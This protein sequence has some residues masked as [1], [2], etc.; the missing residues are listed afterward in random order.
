VAFEH[1]AMHLETFL[2]MLVQSSDTLPPPGITRP[3]FASLRA[4]EKTGSL[5]EDSWIEVPNMTIDVGIDDP[6]EP[7]NSVPRYLGW[8]NEKPV[9]KGIEV[10][11]FSVRTHPITN[12]EYA[13][14]LHTTSTTGTPASWEIPTALVSNGIPGTGQDETLRNGCPTELSEFIGSLSVKTVFG[15]VPLNL[16]LDWPVMASYGELSSCVKW[17]GGRIPSA[18]EVRAAY[19][20]IE[21]LE[22]VE[23]KLARGIDAVNGFVHKPTPKASQLKE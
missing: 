5:G 12:G 19:Q 3:D 17:M 4:W 13:K 20:Y 1:E 22:L 9:R 18:N 15:P 2:Y 23:K 11:P 21:E 10:S 14:Y 7:E 6:E 8:D 16:A